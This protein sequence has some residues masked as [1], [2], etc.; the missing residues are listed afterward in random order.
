MANKTYQELID[1]AR[2]LLQD[3][4]DNRFSDS[5]LLNI[6]NRGLQAL[7][8]IRP[9]AFYTMFDANDLNVPEVVASGADEALNQVNWDTTFPFEGQFYPPLISYIVGMAEV[10]DDEF[11][12]DNRAGIM[13]TQFR[14][15]VIGL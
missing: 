10:T 8:R 1:E 15:T 9:D 6:L 5:F 2:E 3:T 7:S 13:L 11:T 12:W 14:N 4:V